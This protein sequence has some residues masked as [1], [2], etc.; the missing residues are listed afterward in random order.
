[1]QEYMG[2]RKEYFKYKSKKIAEQAINKR[3]KY[4][5]LIKEREKTEQ[6]NQEKVF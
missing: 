4:F 1:M 2:K 5:E 6:R 3:L